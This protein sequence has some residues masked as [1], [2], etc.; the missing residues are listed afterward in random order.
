MPVVRRVAARRVA[1]ALGLMLVTASLAGCLQ[2][3]SRPTPAPIATPPPTEPPPATPTPTPG[4]PTPTPIPTFTT[5]T[6]KGGDTLTSI[7]KKFHVTPR[8]IAYWNRDTYPTLDPES[9][10]YKPNALQVGWVLRVLPYGLY[11]SPP[12]TPDPSLE[13]TPVPTE[14]LGPP[15]DAPSD[16]ASGAPS[17][18]PAASSG[19]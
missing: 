19:G 1:A 14:Y 3:A 9:P 7:G 11:S 4:P 8:S 18:S 6:V 17:G 10:K 15:T 12:D 13:V 16:A 2:M 5:Y